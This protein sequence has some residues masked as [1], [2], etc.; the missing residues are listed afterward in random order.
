[1]LHIIAGGTDKT[2]EKSCECSRYRCRDLN[3][4]P[5]EYKVGVPS[6]RE[7]FHFVSIF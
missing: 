1:M 4:R 6:T 7:L 2:E 5:L 3:Q